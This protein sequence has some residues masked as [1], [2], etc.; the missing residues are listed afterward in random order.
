MLIQP[1]HEW[2]RCL[3][4]PCL[5]H[6]LGRREEAV[7][8][9]RTA[10]RAAQGGLRVRHECEGSACVLCMSAQLFWLCRRRY[11]E[12]EMQTRHE[13]GGRG[14]VLQGAVG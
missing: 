7:K 11:P 4:A 2:G 3:H 6:L 14:R 12:G 5:R 8:G 10:D 9:R 1:L 13:A